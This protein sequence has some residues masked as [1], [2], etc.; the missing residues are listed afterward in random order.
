MSIGFPQ[1]ASEAR[2]K[3]RLQITKIYEAHNPSWGPEG[4]DGLWIENRNMDNNSP[5]ILFFPKPPA[6]RTRKFMERLADLEVEPYKFGG[7]ENMVGLE[8]NWQTETITTPFTDRE[9]GKARIMDLELPIEVLVRP[10]EKPK[11]EAPIAAPEETATTDAP[12]PASEGEEESKTPFEVIAEIKS[13]AVGKT[14]KELIYA[15]SKTKSIMDATDAQFRKDLTS[16]D[17]TGSLVFTGELEED[18]SGKF[19]KGANF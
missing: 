17:L 3:Q 18:E 16:G 8:M 12:V 13:M 6:Y 10:G 7:W 19:Q 1:S 15:V 14:L 2:G 9:T 4:T 5:R 11:V